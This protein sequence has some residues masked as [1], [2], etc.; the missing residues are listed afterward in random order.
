MMIRLIS[1]L[2]L[3][4]MATIAQAKQPKSVSPDGIEP[5]HRNTV[6]FDNRV[7]NVLFND[8]KWVK[9]P[10]LCARNEECIFAL[11]KDLVIIKSKEPW[12]KNGYVIK[13]PGATEQEEALFAQPC[14]S[15]TW[16]DWCQ[17]SR[18]DKLYAEFF[19]QADKIFRE[20]MLKK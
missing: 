6:E 1:A 14:G 17:N 8:A 19:Q 18:I 4:C 12:L 13:Y 10:G 15:E 16:S 7:K 5:W 2:V 9:H 11:G 3:V 20:T